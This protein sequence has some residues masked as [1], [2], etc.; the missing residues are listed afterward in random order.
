MRRR[1]DDLIDQLIADK[2][3]KLPVKGGIDEV[4]RARSHARRQ[5]ADTMRAQAN[6][7]RTADVEIRRIKIVR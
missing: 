6:Q 7:I 4:A 1:K 5:E 2:G 3:A